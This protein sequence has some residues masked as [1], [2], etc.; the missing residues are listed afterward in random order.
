MQMDKLLLVPQRQ[1]IGEFV[2]LAETYGCGFEYNDFFLPALLDDEE[3]LEKRIAFYALDENRP[4]FSTLHGAFLDVTIFSDDPRIKEV[5]VMRVKQSLEVAKR[6]GASAVI[7]HT[8]YLPNFLLQSYRENWVDRNVAFWSEMAQ[9]YPMLS[10][11]MENMFDTDYKLLAKLGEKMR[12]CE[13]FGICF[14]Y[15]HAQVF[16]D[17]NKIGEWVETLAPFVKHLHINDHDFEADLHLALGDGKTDWQRFCE[18]YERYF[19][20]T[21]VLLEVTGIEK[22]RKSLDYLSRL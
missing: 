1:E 5:S 4:A 13:N 12:S 11:Y 6:L 9:Q 7:F 3:E 14:D 21:S 19:Q 17:E 16:G 20:N 8:N 10:I 15:S 18:H 2:Q 22:T